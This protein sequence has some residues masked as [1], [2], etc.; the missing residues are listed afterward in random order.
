M[1]TKKD[2]P[3]IIEV[4]AMPISEDS[5]TQEIRNGVSS[6]YIRFSTVIPDE[7]MLDF[8]KIS[9]IGNNPEKDIV[10]RITLP[11]SQA[12]ALKDLLNQ[13]KMLS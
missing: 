8:Y 13:Q 4:D 7:V 3:K 6:N 9:M 1:S 12:K 2:S 10:A 11:L 5:L